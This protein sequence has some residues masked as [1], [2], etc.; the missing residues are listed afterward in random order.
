[1]YAA[2][3]NGVENLWQKSLDGKPEHQIT[4]FQSD[5]LARFQFSS[6]GKTLGVLQHHTDSDV[7]LLRDTS[8]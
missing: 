7:V 3:E 8:K 1:M 6:D 2:K 5:T 4:H